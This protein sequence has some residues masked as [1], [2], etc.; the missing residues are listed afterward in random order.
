[1][2]GWLDIMLVLLIGS[3]LGRLSQRFG[4]PNAVAQ[5]LLGVVLGTAVLGWVP[6]GPVLHALGEIGVVLLLGV[7]GLQFG[8]DRMMLAGWAGAAVAT[9]G[10]VLS[11]LG[12]Y[13]ISSLFGSSSDEAI[14]VGLAL[15]ATSIGITVQV[16]HQFGLIGHRVADIVVAAAVI[17]D[18]IVLYLVG[19]VHGF[20]NNEQGLQGV[21]FFFVFTV[22]LLGGLYF[23]SRG[24]GRWVIRRSFA[25]N[26]WQRGFLILSAVSLGALST[27]HFGLSL[28]VGAFFA[29]VGV[30]DGMGREARRSSTQTLQPLVLI[31]M[32]FFFVMIGVQAQW[33]ILE[34]P[35]MLWLVPVLIVFAVVAKVAGGVLGAMRVV[36]GRE[37]WIIGFGMVAR[38]EVALVIAALAFEQGHLTYP[39]FV[40]LVLTTIVV[41]ILGPLFTAPFAK[42]LGSES[43][44][45]TVR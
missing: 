23:V 34:K 15:G 35:A 19:A 32:P 3:L 2:N 42:M 30:G 37:R 27:N 28:I 29:G 43:S 18:V 39:V 8:I 45:R 16:L 38:G 21:L 20:L 17:D 1:M 40:A 5:V 9:F 25:K 24:L 31:L 6:H 26:Q 4:F 10:I 7:T 22:L 44:L 14:Y 33:N 12:G 11:V 13:A 36:R 41:A